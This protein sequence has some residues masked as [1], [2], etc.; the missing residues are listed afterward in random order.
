MSYLSL[1]FK[2]DKPLMW[3]WSLNLWI[4]SFR[5]N[6][7][8]CPRLHSIATQTE[9]PLP[10]LRKK[11]ERDRTLI[12]S[13]LQRVPKKKKKKRNQEWE[14]SAFWPYCGFILDSARG[15]WRWG[16]GGRCLLL[17]DCSQDPEIH[18]CFA[19]QCEQ[20]WTNDISNVCFCFL[21]QHVTNLHIESTCVNFLR[22]KPLSW[23]KTLFLEAFHPILCNKDNLKTVG[24]I[25]SG[26]F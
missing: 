23:N 14:H 21:K 16:G 6:I 10:L 11:A 12:L 1:Q 17:Q 2:H 15:I 24:L 4:I 22:D 9:I 13:Q 18:D 19:A 5:L 20:W 3:R 25:S 7:P 8:P 26:T